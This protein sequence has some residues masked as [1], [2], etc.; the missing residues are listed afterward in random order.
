MVMSFW[1]R[2]A[3]LIIGIIL[4]LYVAKCQ[5]TETVWKQANREISAK[6]QD[7][8]TEITETELN[9]FIK[10]FPQYKEL[11]F[12]DGLTVS[13]QVARPSKWL[14]WKSKIWFVYHQW[15]ADRFFYVQQRIAALLFTLSIRR[16]AKALIKQLAAWPESSAVQQ[17]LEL[18][19]QRSE[20]G[21]GGVTELQLIEQKEEILKKLFK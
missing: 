12:D 16:N 2:L 13:Y 6:Q 10:L 1:K 17:M 8:T 21:E 9:D 7:Y 4:I 20:A 5:V 11:G 19:K 15:D 3:W 18:Q 14:D